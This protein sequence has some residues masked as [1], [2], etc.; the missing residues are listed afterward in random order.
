MSEF[1][2]RKAPNLE[3]QV[4]GCLGRMANLFYL[5]AG[6]ARNR[7]LTNKPHCDDL[8]LARTQSDVAGI[9]SP[10]GDQ[11]EDELK[12]SELRRNSSNGKLNGTPIKMLVAH[13]MS[14]EVASK[15]NSSNVIAKL[16]G[17]EALP[18][19]HSELAVHRIQSKGYS[20]NTQSHS[21]VPLDYWEN[22]VHSRGQDEYKDV[23][24]I[25]KQSEQINFV[26]DL[27]LQEMRDIDNP[28]EKKMTLIRQK[29]IEAKRLSTD[30]KLRQ[31]EEF[32][33]ALEIL[34]SNKELFLKVLQEPN[35]IFTKHL[36]NV[37]SSLPPPRARRI[38]V[39]RPKIVDKDV[40]PDL[41]K[42]NDKQ[43]SKLV[44]MGQSNGCNKINARIPSWKADDSQANG[45]NKINP[46]IPSWKADDN[47]I[48]SQATRIVVLKP[49]PWKTHDIK[50]VSP[51]SLSPRMSNGGN[52][53]SNLEDDEVLKEASKDINENLS[54]HRRDE[55]L[56]S[57][58]FSNGYI[59]D[60]SS[61]HLS[62]NEHEE[63]NL[64][65]SDFMSPSFKQSW[66]HINNKFGGSPCSSSSFGRASYS[67]ESS[68]CR[69]AKKRLSERWAMMASNGS[70]QEHWHAR[71]SSS[72]LG[73]MLALSDTRKSLRADEGT[74]MGQELRESPLSLNSNLIKD[75]GFD[76]SPRNLL[77]SKSVPVS[78]TVY[79]PRLNVQVP[80]SDVCKMHVSEGLSKAKSGKSSLKGKV[81]NLF[82]SKNRKSIKDKS[83]K[84]PS[85]GECSS[86]QSHNFVG[87]K[88][89][90]HPL[91]ESTSKASSSNLIG[92]QPRQA[93]VS[94]ESV[95]H[96]AKSKSRG[97]QNQEQPSPVSVFE[98][99]FE[100]D[101]S[102]TPESSSSSKQDQR[103][104]QVS[105]Y[106][107]R[108]S[109]IG[110][111]PLIEPMAR[112]TLLWNDY[113][114]Q[115][116]TPRI[117]MQHSS[118]P[119]AEDVEEDW[120]SL[121]QTLL[122]AAGI[123]S[124]AQC[125]TFFA[126]WHSLESPLSP[127]LRETYV[128][129]AD[130]EC[131]FEAKRRLRR[132]NRKL[133]FDCVNAAL[134]D[135]TGQESGTGLRTR[136]R[137]EANDASS[138]LLLSPTLA[139]RVC[140]WMKEWCS[141]EGAAAAAAEDSVNRSSLVVDRVV[142]GEWVGW[143]KRGVDGVGQVIGRELLEDLLSEAVVDF[144]R[145]G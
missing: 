120:R 73:E 79:G 8:S 16:M 50:A 30:E 89:M 83:S 2:N 34:N 42:N 21:G 56:L 99:P 126:R 127:S 84:C 12:V 64:S 114:A 72:T 40:V 51:A 5:N 119:R 45:C 38:T 88:S 100:E 116:A 125:H 57:S 144:T 33:D 49:G 74:S 6:V 133:V 28:S 94:C 75:E 62:E 4:P 135:L 10:I 117:L 138:S 35:S 112:R 129:H 128:S 95:S 107:D 92:S 25:K 106:P 31:S 113:T 44:Q 108:S 142:C 87:E 32:Q 22:E 78:S 15:N 14:K 53:C 70:Y 139:N 111:S 103:G 141:T 90:P 136:L 110:K 80:D 140:S 115:I 104:L 96:G 123:D 59:G 13:E 69:E 76:N 23:Y 41:G 61:F 98:V 101:D 124:E 132:S 81:S 66:N 52:S 122:S 63:G 37:Q 47:P 27:S 11:I 58:V 93:M 102:T 130:K 19:G 43:T 137:N 118:S 91:D 17:L 86:N 3:K 24:E 71:K 7:L 67:P 82:F 55:T 77:R 143:M 46:P 1:Q 85:N 105:G 26:G 36:Y 29:F 20:Q 48:P 134:V 54:G 39:L 109:M 131:M 97:I 9:L 18:Q 145:I 68:V 121:V 65:D 60:E